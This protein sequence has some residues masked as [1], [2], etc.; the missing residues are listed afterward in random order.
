MGLVIE[1][2]EAVVQMLI[3]LLLRFCLNIRILRHGSE[4]QY[5]RK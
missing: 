4:E 1:V 2:W 5:H 3:E